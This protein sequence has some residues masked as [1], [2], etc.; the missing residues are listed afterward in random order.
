MA[1]IRRH[2]LALWNQYRSEV[3]GPHLSE[4]RAWRAQCAF[5]AGAHSVAATI[6][7]HVPGAADIEIFSSIRYE[8]EQFYTP[9][10]G[11]TRQ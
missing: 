11:V 6:A 7:E 2:I 1:A 9:G 5:Y 8:L 3:L 4:E 10:C